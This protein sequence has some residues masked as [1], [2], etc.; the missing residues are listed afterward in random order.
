MP[1]STLFGDRQ[2]KRITEF[3]TAENLL[4][5][6]IPAVVAVAGSYAATQTRVASLESRLQ[7][8]DNQGSVAFQKQKDQ[9]AAQFA[10][11]QAQLAA[12]DEKLTSL[13][14]NVSDIKSDLRTRK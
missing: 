7:T 6:L 14:D 5:I 8:I 2:P 10:A 11:I 1:P 9:N 13:K 12:I 4:K 3:F